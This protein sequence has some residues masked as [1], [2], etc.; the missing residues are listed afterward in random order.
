VQFYEESLKQFT[1]RFQDQKNYSVPE[2]VWTIQF[3]GFY[4]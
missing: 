2:S 3:Y 4:Q 1:E